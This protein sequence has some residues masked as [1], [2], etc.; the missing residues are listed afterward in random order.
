MSR[1]GLPLIVV[2]LSLI[3]LF[4]GVI[5]LGWKGLLALEESATHVLLVSRIPRVISLLISGMSLAVA[6]SIMQLITANRFVTPSTGS[7]TEWAKLGLLITMIYAPQAN[8]IT[9]TVFTFIFA[10]IGTLSFLFIIQ[11]ARLKDVV[12]VPLVGILYGNIVSS[13]TTHVAYQKDLIQSMS[14]W[15]QGSFGLIMKGRYEIL[16]FS[17]PFFIL[18]LLYANRFTVVSMGK[19]IS[20]NLGIR[21]MATIQVGLVIVSV[22]S[23]LVLVTVGVIPFIGL[24][25]PNLVS[26]F[27]GDNLEKNTFTIALCGGLFLLVCD[28]LAR[29]LLYPF[30]VPISIT[31]AVLGC[32]LFLFLLLYRRYHAT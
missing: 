16:Y 19:D 10:F 28:I 18:S 9:K 4:I 25:I 11:K 29:L 27:K 17:V 31:A 6:G 21:Y 22:I 32:I 2:I 23:S 5:P 30:E 12:L 15:I 20:S 8:S 1:Y 7:T 13:L 3:S 26:I 24:V 14:S